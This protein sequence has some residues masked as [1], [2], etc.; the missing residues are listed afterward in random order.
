MWTQQTIDDSTKAGKF[1]SITWR[2]CRGG[3]AETVENGEKLA[4]LPVR[5]QTTNC[6][7]YYDKSKKERLIKKGTALR[8]TCKEP[9]GEWSY[10]TND[11]IKLELS[12]AGGT[13]FTLKCMYGPTVGQVREFF[14]FEFPEVD[15]IK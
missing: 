2:G 13:L 15:E 10:G 11:F 12:S 8:R 6:G 5:P 4:A 3:G 1:I 9:E 14:D 7:L